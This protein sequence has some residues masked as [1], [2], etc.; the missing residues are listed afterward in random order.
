MKPNVRN[1]IVSNDFMR[2][3][4][5]LPDNKIKSVGDF[6]IQFVPGEKRFDG[7]NTLSPKNE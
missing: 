3:E 2:T 7:W 6:Y 1:V 5:K 4:H